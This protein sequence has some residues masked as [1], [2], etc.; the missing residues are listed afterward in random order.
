MTGDYS[1]Q[2]GDDVQQPWSFASRDSPQQSQQQQSQEMGH[3]SQLQGGAASSVVIPNSHAVTVEEFELFQMC[4]CPCV[5]ECVCYIYAE[6]CGKC[7]ECQ[8][9][10]MYKKETGSKGPRLCKLARANVDEINL[11][12]YK[13]EYPRH[14]IKLTPERARAMGFAMRQLRFTRKVFGF[15]LEQLGNEEGLAERDFARRNELNMQLEDEY[16]LWSVKALKSTYLDTPLLH[17]HM[18]RLRK[19]H[20]P[21]ITAPLM[22]INMDT[23]ARV[24]AIRGAV[25]AHWEALAAFHITRVAQGFRGRCAARN[26]RLAI[27]RH[28]AVLR[29]QATYRGYHDRTFV[30][31]YLKEAWQNRAA[32]VMQRAWRRFRDTRTFRGRARAKIWRLKN[33]AA[34]KLG[35]AF[36]GYMTRKY[37]GDVRSAAAAAKAGYEARKGAVLGLAR[38]RREAIASAAALSIQRVWR[39]VLGRRAVYGRRAA[40]GVNN[41]RL[42]SLTNR[43]LASGDLWGFIA[44]INADYN[45]AERDKVREVTRARAFVDQVIRAREEKGERAWRQWQEFKNRAGGGGGG[46]VR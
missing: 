10:A 24:K 46:G 45:L 33:R 28:F 12:T 8:S 42:E 35:A 1:F 34:T 44:A 13:I 18:Q 31:P 15:C 7:G 19:D 32:A 20:I 22:K 41:P 3:Q 16:H 38:A 26:R 37:I 14:L 11:G 29:I 5:R 9:N 36:R 21:G 43:F 23:L 17:G 2:H 6:G 30:I 4:G 39:G 27:L 40:G 25:Y